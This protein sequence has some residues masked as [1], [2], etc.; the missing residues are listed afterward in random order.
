MRGQRRPYIVPI[1]TGSLF[2][3]QFVSIGFV[4]LCHTNMKFK[5]PK[6]TEDILYAYQVRSTGILVMIRR[7][8]TGVG[9][10]VD[11]FGKSY[12]F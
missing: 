12:L 7:M 10:V 6:L 11:R 3:K 5:G 9:Q 1:V 4:Y 2:V 8:I